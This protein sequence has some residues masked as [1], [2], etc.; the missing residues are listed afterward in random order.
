MQFRRF[1]PVKPE[2]TCTS[3]SRTAITSSKGCGW[4][5]RCENTKG[6][7]RWVLS[8]ARQRGFSPP[9]SGSKVENSDAL[10][11][12]RL[13]RVRNRGRLVFRRTGRCHPE[14]TTRCGWDQRPNGHL[15]SIGFTDDGAGF[16]TTA[17]ATSA[18]TASIALT[19]QSHCSTRPARL[20]ATSQLDC[21]QRYSPMAANGISM[22]RR[23]FPIRCR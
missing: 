9:S 20:K 3:K 15:I 8:F 2:K 10:S 1:W 5:R 22:T 7:C 17:R 23:N 21:H 16:T 19:W 13:G 4:W 14:L 6:L 18:T 11:S 12:L